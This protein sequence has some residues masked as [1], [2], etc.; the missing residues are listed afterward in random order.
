LLIKTHVH[1]KPRENIHPPH[2]KQQPFATSTKP[3]SVIKQKG[4]PQ[5]MLIGQASAWNWAGFL[6]RMAPVGII[7]LLLNGLILGTVYREEMKIE[8]SPFHPREAPFDRKLASK[9][10]IVFSGLLLAFLLGAPMDISALAA[11]S[12]L[13]VWANRPPKEAFDAVDWSLLLFFGGLFVIIEG[14][15]KSE[16]SWLSMMIPQM[17]GHADSFSGLLRFAAISAGGSNLFSNVPFV[18]LLRKWVSLSPHASMLWLALSASSTFAGNLT[19]VGSVAN[20]I[21]AQRSKDECPL[22]FYAFLK[23][24]IPI[25]ILTVFA[26]ALMILLYMRWHLL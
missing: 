13:L 19:L 15:T 17:M 16:R 14:V 25:T 7:A 9:T 24:G 23:V 4:N 22:S 18:L 21:V 20:L 1:P 3:G 11:S 8:P 12:I 6:A 5:N 10:V 26:S 2:P